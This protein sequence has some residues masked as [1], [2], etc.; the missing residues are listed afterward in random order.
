MKKKKIENGQFEYICN[1]VHTNGNRCQKTIVSN[2][3]KNNYISGFG[4]VCDKYHNHPNR[5]YYCKKHLY[6]KI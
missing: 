3:F 4:Y 6:N 5:N 1:Y 2:L